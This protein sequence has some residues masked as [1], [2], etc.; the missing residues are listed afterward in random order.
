MMTP[1]SLPNRAV[2]VRGG[3]PAR[4]GPTFRDWAFPQV[5]DPEGHS[6]VTAGSQT[7]P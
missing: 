4:V 6:V 5:W 1:S 3:R 2:W 7:A